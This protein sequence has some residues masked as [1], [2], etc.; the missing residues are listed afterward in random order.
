MS[1]TTVA[2]KYT[3]R[4]KDIPLIKFDLLKETVTIR[5]IQ[6]YDYALKINYI[7]K[8]QQALLPYSL[9]NELSPEN[10]LLWIEQRKAPKNRR[11]VEQLMQTISDKSNPLAYIDISHA[12]SLNDALWITNDDMIAAWQDF[13]LYSHPF[14]QVLAYIAF[15]GHSEK[16]SG[17]VT[18]PEYTSVGALKKC[19]SNRTD[20]I[21]LLKGDDFINYSDGRSQATMEF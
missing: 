20:G 5:G 19:W 17:V 15:T 14:N 2:G 4:N 13:N 18:S 9:R 6:A 8:E 1:N 11:F 7:N 10:L 16:I 21:Y 12:L 3:L